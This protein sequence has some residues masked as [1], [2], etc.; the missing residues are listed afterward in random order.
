LAGRSTGDLGDPDAGAQVDSLVAVPVGEHLGCLPAEHPQQRQLVSAI[1]YAALCPTLL[2]RIFRG[3]PPEPGGYLVAQLPAAGFEGA[4]AV[5]LQA[6]GHLA[7]V[8]AERFQF[9]EHLPRIG[10]GLSR[11]K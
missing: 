9:A 5:A 11:R 10:S 6:L 4:H 7:V 3:P 1:T 8:D 2:P